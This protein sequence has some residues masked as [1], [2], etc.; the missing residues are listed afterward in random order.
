MTYDLNSLIVICFFLI[1]LYL[2]VCIDIY[3]HTY[4]CAMIPQGGDQAA[5]LKKSLSSHG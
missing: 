1:E 5:A 3:T 4:I 2:Y